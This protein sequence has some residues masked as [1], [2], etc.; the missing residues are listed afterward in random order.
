M[1]SPSN[2]TLYAIAEEMATLDQIFEDVGG[3]VTPETEPIFKAWVDEMAPKLA[4]KVDAIGRYWRELEAQEQACRYE[5]TRLQARAKARA[6]KIKGL[7]FV[8]HQ[9]MHRLGARKLEGQTFTVS[10]QK[11]GGRPALR[12][13]MPTTEGAHIKFLRAEYEIGWDTEALR[14]AIAAKDPDVEGYAELAPVG[15]SVRLR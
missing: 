10:L 13:L 9:A 14:Q 5:I 1:T 3:E 2:A 8:L 12:I 7:T 4:A 6:N 11:N 15:E